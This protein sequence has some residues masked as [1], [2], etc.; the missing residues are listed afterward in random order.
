MARL[1]DV[2]ASALLREFSYLAH[3]SE[4]ELSGQR[5]LQILFKKLAVPTFS[6][7]E[8]H[9]DPTPGS[10]CLQATYTI[11]LPERMWRR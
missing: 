7:H 3:I 6:E 1:K 10:F 2:E 8:V 11:T 4:G 9:V 5:S